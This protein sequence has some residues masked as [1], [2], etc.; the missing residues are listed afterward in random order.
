MPYDIFISYAREDNI[1][2][3]VTELKKQIEKDYFTF[4]N[5][6]LKCFFDTEDIR[7]MDYWE[8]N[9]LKALKESHLF[10]A[11]LTPN[12]IKSEF[13][14]LEI[15][16]YLRHEYSKGVLGDGIAPICFIEIPDLDKSDFSENNPN[17]LKK[18]NTRQRFD[19]QLW[20]KDGVNSLQ[21]NNVKTSLNELVKSIFSRIT[22]MKNTKISDGNL[23]PPSANFV[24]R[25]D[26]LH[27]IHNS[28]D[29]GKFGII[30]AVHGVGGLGKTETAIKYAY[31]YADCFSGG[32][33]QINCTNETNITSALKKLELDLKLTFTEEEKKDELQGAK[34]IL[35]VLE[36]RANKGNINNTGEIYTQKPAALLILDDVNFPELIQSPGIDLFAGKDWLKVLATTRKGEKEFGLAEHKHKFIPIDILP[37]EDALD[38]IESY[39]PEQKFNCLEEK[40]TAEQIVK[41]LG[42]FTLAIETAALFLR[43]NYGKIKFTQFYEMLKQKGAAIGIDLA[44]EQ[45][46]SSINHT[47]LIT[48]TLA[49]TLDNLSAVENLILNYA[50]LLPYDTIPLPWIKELVTK[51]YPKLKNQTKTEFI[52]PWIKNINHLTSLRLLQ[53]VDLDDNT[54]RIVR[55][56]QLIQEVIQNRCKNRKNILNNLFTHAITRSEYL[57]T[58]WYKKNEQWEINPLV[59]FTELL[60]DKFYPQATQLVLSFG[61]WLYQIYFNNKHKKII[62]QAIRLLQTKENYKQTELAIL[63]S[64]LAMVEQ[65]LGNLN[66]AKEYLLKAIKIDEINPEPNQPNQAIFYSNL[67]SIEQDLGNFIF[68][69]DLFLKAHSINVSNYEPNHS[70]LAISYSNLA[71]IEQNLGNLNFAKDYLVKAIKINESNFDPNHPTLAI[72]YSNL[73]IVEQALGNLNVAKDYLIKAIKID[74]SNYEPNHPNLAIDYSILA[75]VEQ[76]L[77]H[78]NIAEGYFIKAIK[79]DE[80]NYE[81]NHPKLGIKYSNFALV[82]KDL[83]N[84]T[85]AKDY[86]IKAIKISELSYEPNHPQLAIYYSNL[87]IVEQNLGNLKEAKNYSLKAVQ[88][89]ELCY[90]Q[91]HLQLAIYY[92][93]LAMVEQDLGNSKGA[94]N[95]LLK[96]IKIDECNYTPN[97][98]HPAILYSNLASV[99]HTL[100][101]LKI[102]KKYLIKAIDI[103]E[104]NFD[105][106]HPVLAT[107]H[108]N[109]AAVELDL[110]NIEEAEK[111]FS[112][113]LG[114][115]EISLPKGHFYTKDSYLFLINL[116][117]QTGR[118]QEADELRVKAKKHGFD[119]I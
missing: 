59:N 15:K 107:L 77:G 21:N 24:G 39:L 89:G 76:T 75:T 42:G 105:T 13:C 92:T 62:L 113:A 71:T 83:G 110:G 45:T 119:N 94:K 98:P 86:L 101:N 6:E 18:I 36:E 48:V 52:D 32:R 31:A 78:L 38:L 63:Y 5:E 95:Y 2:G 73:A 100:G 57:E 41:A 55:M 69:K 17:W 79:I 91:N 61:S 8:L 109:L 67:A 87:A 20:F 82:E 85:K 43:E 58:N 30:T 65:D 35:N 106:N 53:V 108:S 3:R 72:R 81:P 104:L 9:I 47:K 27:N 12:Y 11:L 1:N 44:G 102:A 4:A 84:F 74:E 111:L 103:D 29:A 60:L 96:A 56:H 70:S 25:N 37:E 90:E 66:I 64:S 114:I 46:I 40:E 88:I 80:L 14:N 7:C 10:L 93:N 54:P 34:R 28:I 19:L 68:A 99:E 23:R 26:E 50:S 22:R 116:F 51:K 118:N 117:M 112:K 49:L 33:W 16:D 97:H 115:R